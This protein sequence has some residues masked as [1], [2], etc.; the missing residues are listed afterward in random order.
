MRVV[1]L[2]ILL[3]AFLAACSSTPTGHSAEPAEPRVTIDAP[4]VVDPQQFLVFL[5]DLNAKLAVGDPRELTDGEQRRVD[6]LT[7]NLRSMLSDI[8]DIDSLNEDQ[9]REIF[10]STQ[11][12][13]ATV[14]GRDEDQVI[15]RR[16]HRV[17]TN[18][19]TTRCR[20]LEEI[21]EDQRRSRMMLNDVFS[22]GGLR[23]QPDA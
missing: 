7:A 10:N 16:D 9:Q 6:R 18:F 5:D 8:S 4:E 14:I 15:C 22:R 11:E 17:G 20:S 12:L 13:W 23:P 19:K 1:V 21:R 3:I 2:A